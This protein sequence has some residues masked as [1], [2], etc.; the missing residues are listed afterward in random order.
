MLGKELSW[1]PLRD[2]WLSLGRHT[3]LRV[4]WG[5]HALS[6]LEIYKVSFPEPKVLQKVIRAA[7]WKGKIALLLL[8]LL[9]TGLFHKI[10]CVKRIQLLKVST[11]RSVPTAYCTEAHNGMDLS[12]VTIRFLLELEQSLWKDR[13]G[14][15]G[16]QPCEAFPRGF[17]RLTLSKAKPSLSWRHFNP[18]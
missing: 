16:S 12:R 8:S 4:L 13:S 2:F 9:Y 5:L 15:P 3:R 7:R 10:F 1:R 6:Q 17:G 14:Y 11:E 18:S